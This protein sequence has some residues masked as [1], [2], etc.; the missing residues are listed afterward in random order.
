MTY[1]MRLIRIV[2]IA[3]SVLVLVV[4]VANGVAFIA[5]SPSVLFNSSGIQVF[6]DRS[7]LY[8]IGLEFAMM[9]IRR[10]PKLVIEVLIFAIA[11]K[12]VITMDT[13]IDFLLGAFAIFILFGVRFLL[14]RK[15][16]NG[17]EHLL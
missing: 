2:E 14:I 15:S 6:M 11:R 10:D 12:M 4:V 9:I 5:H 16:D 17:T 13:G 3:L 7:L 1:L 8:V